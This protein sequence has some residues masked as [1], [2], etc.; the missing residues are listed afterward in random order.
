MVNR[1]RVVLAGFSGAPGVATFYGTDL[2]TLRDGL[3]NFW[4]GLGPVGIFPSGFTAT[5]ETSGDI[6]NSG[7]GAIEGTWTAPTIA[8]S[9]SGGSAQYAGPAGATVTWVTNTVADGSR[10]R[11]RTFLVPGAASAFQDDGTLIPSIVA[12][13][14]TVADAFVAATAPTFVVWHRPRLARAA[15]GTLPAQT[16]H[17]GSLAPITGSRVPDRVQ[18]LRSRRQ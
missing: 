3:T 7:T 8:P 9:G 18:I 15:T 5:I 10:I 1:V 14:K 16:A 6:I 11:G 2:A 12:G 4:G 13:I 17:P